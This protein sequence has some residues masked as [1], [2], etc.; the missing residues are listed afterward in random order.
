MERKKMDGKQI[1]WTKEEWKPTKKKKMKN[2][3]KVL[4]MHSGK[5]NKKPTNRLQNVTKTQINKL[6]DRNGSLI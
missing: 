6:Q 1:L 3:H 5:F 2:T 4:K